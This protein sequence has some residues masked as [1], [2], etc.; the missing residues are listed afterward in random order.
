[1]YIGSEELYTILGKHP[2]YTKQISLS[3]RGV[4]VGLQQKLIINLVL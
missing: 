3:L 2:G 1:M 4:I